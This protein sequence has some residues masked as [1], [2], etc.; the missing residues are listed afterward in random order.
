MFVA[1]VSHVPTL[2]CRGAVR[3]PSRALV[4]L[5]RVAPP[6]L[7]GTPRPA[8]AFLAQLIAHREGIDW[9]REKRRAAPEAAA[10]AYR[11][12]A[13]RPVPAAH[14]RATI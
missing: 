7:A 13:G 9:T 8:A 4:P 14:L 1:A 6:L 3:P 12:G 10:S 5:R 11:A 2:P